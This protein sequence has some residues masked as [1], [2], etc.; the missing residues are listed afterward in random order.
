LPKASVNNESSMRKVQL[1]IFCLIAILLAGCGQ[2]FNV[3]QLGKGDIDFVSDS[4]RKETERLLYELMEKL[5]RR[6]PKELGKQQNATVDAQI[7]RLKVA[8]KEDSPLLIDGIE[9][10][11]VL[12][13]AFDKNYVGDRVFVL[14]GGLM[15][16]MHKSY[17][18]HVEFYIF[19]KLDQQKLY[20]SAR[21][22]EIFSWRLRTDKNDRNELLLL[23]THI[24]GENTN[25]SFE[26][27][28]SKLISIQDM[29]ALI[30]S[31]GDRRTVNGVTH[32]V[33]K[34]IFLPI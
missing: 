15:S 23:S 25:L 14:V 2:G 33:A 31:D 18:Y 30:A 34:M 22:I 13:L 28:V 32:G 20:N 27:L 24:D 1:S 16:M 9:G 19:D 11:D 17:G 26:R 21:N 6:N 12:Q 4:H 3:K 7:A 29:M 5:Y 10:I 8:G